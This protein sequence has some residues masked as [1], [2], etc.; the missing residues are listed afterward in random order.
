[1]KSLPAPATT[2]TLHAPVAAPGAIA[3]GPVASGTN[4]HSQT[5]LLGIGL[6]VAVM[7][8]LLVAGFGFYLATRP[9]KDTRP[10]V[11]AIEDAEGNKVIVVKEE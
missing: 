6:A 3:K 2:R 10:T 9:E 4:T 8:L 5:L 1:M 11:R 7:A